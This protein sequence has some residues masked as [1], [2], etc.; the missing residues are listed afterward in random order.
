MLCKFREA[1]RSLL[2]PGENGFLQLK[3]KMKHSTVLIAL[4]LGLALVATGCHHKPRSITNI[5]GSNIRPTGQEPGLS[6]GTVMPTGPEIQNTGIPIAE[7]S[8][9]S[10]LWNGEGKEDAEKFK[11]DIVYFDT[12]SAVIKKTEQ[13]KLQDVADYFKGNATDAVTVQ[14]HCDER[15]TEGYNLTLGDKRALAVREYLGTLGV[16]PARV[17]TISYGESRPVEKGHSEAAWKKNRRGV[18]ILLQPK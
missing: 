10:K 13:T 3:R 16:D 7:D 14:G 6:P 9:Y 11:A 15:G 17:H 1:V 4:T 12:D 5:P 8:K 18:F 2:G